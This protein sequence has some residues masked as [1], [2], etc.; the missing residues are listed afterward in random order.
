[1]HAKLALAQVRA[2]DGLRGTDSGLGGTGGRSGL[3]AGAVIGVQYFLKGRLHV[4]EQGFDAP[5]GDFCERFSRLDE[6]GDEFNGQAGLKS[7]AIE[8][9]KSGFAI[10]TDRSTA[11]RL[12]LE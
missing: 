10:D 4:A 6:G 7:A 9:E 12:K 3:S 1:L 5:R 8:N 2:S 11:V